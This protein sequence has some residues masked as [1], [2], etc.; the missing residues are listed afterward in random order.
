MEAA[1]ALRCRNQTQLRARL[2][3]HARSEDPLT[4]RRVASDLREVGGVAAKSILIELLADTDEIVR[5]TAAESLVS[6]ADDGLVSDLV[7]AYHTAAPPVQASLVAVFRRM[8]SPRLFES[9]ELSLQR[10]SPEQ[11]MSVARM[12]AQIGDPK[13]LALLESLGQS[14]PVEEVRR[15]AQTSAR[16][17]MEQLDSKMDAGSAEPN[18][19]VE[20][21]WMQRL[22]D[23]FGRRP[24][25]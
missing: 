6:V 10:G 21:D 12:V 23:L 11:R 17:L 4:R 2:L 25:Q 19:P 22:R 16:R 1:S 9:L 7:D 14:D 15:K 18:Q 5:D 13:G 3:P 20:A 24:P 8:R